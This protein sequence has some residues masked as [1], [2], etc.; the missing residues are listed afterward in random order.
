MCELNTRSAGY[1][2]TALTTKLIGQ[3]LM[4]DVEL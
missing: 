2:P 3:I 4:F 1:M